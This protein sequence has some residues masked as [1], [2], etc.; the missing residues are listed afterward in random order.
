[1]NNHTSQSEVY[2]T[3][4]DPSDISYQN[5]LPQDWSI[6]ANSSECNQNTDSSSID[7]KIDLPVD[8][9]P[10]EKS[11]SLLEQCLR[12]YERFYVNF[13]YGTRL[14]VGET[15]SI[16]TLLEYLR[17]KNLQVSSEEKMKQ[18]ECL[19]YTILNEDCNENSPI[20]DPNFDGSESFKR[21]VLDSEGKEWS[22]PMKVASRILVE[23]STLQ[24]FFQSSYSN[25][26]LESDPF[27]K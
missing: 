1:M 27:G 18:L 16:S 9:T 11:D 3:S 21:R 23:L 7:E 12:Q 25:N 8:K 17:I 20:N 6:G 26:I 13:I 5:S 2:C 15:K 10:P 19:L 22:D 14:K 24:T 4:T